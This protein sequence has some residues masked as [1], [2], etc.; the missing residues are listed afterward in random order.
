MLSRTPRSASRVEASPQ[1]MLNLQRNGVHQFQRPDA[2]L[3]LDPD[4]TVLE[5]DAEELKFS[6]ISGSHLMFQSALQRRSPGF[7]T[8]DIG[9]LRRAD[10]T[11]WSTWVGVDETIGESG[12]GIEA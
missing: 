2:S 9:F 8:N 7:E 4:R 3:P 11:S 10:Q 6:K 12:R 1:A 5:G